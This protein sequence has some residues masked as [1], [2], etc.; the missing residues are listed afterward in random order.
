MRKLYFPLACAF[1]ATGIL[2]SCNAASS[3]SAGGGE[4]PISETSDTFKLINI[5]QEDV[6][7]IEGNIDSLLA[8]QNTGDFAATVEFYL[9]TIF[10][11]PESKEQ[12]IA[13]LGMNREYG[14]IQTF[15]ENELLWVSPYYQEPN[16]QVC[17][18]M[19][20]I[21]HEIV[22]GGKMADKFDA[23]EVNVRDMYGRD[24]MTKDSEN[25]RYLVDGPAK[26]FFFKMPTGEIY[27]LNEEILRTSYASGLFDSANL[28]DMKTFEVAARKAVGI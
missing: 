3:S 6:E 12:L 5:P 21:K 28:L 1:L 2:T 25:K 27:M 23:Y 7:R 11:T 16:Y 13:Q 17:F 24:F 14:V 10:P 22:I 15:E 26:F 4:T 19:F 20:R 9:P 8:G 18:A